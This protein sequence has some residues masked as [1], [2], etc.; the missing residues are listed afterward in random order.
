MR[1]LVASD[2]KLH[3][4]P[5]GRLSAVIGVC[6]HAWG[7]GGGMPEHDGFD[8]LAAFPVMQAHAKGARVA[9]QQ[10]LP[11]FV[12]IVGGTVAGIYQNLQQ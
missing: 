8:P 4:G 3:G 11:E 10:G 2:P 5:L 7:R 9:G 12:A 6:G 1:C